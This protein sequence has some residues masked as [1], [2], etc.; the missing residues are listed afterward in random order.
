MLNRTALARCVEELAQQS[1]VSG[2][3]VAMILADIDNFKAINDTAGHATGDAVLREIAYLLRK[4]MRAF[5]AAYR[6]GGEEFLTLLA[7]TE[8]HAAQAVAECLRT[9]IEQERFSGGRQVTI[10]CGASGLVRRRRLRLR[11]RLRSR[12]R[13]AL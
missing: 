9:E 10:S 12:R 5:E 6:L 11:H 8:I 2:Q 3:P 4:R 7:G 13:S 1:Q